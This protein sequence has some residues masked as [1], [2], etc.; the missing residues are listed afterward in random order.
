MSVS[1]RLCEETLP[2]PPF[3]IFY[4]VGS[5]PCQKSWTSLRSSD[6]SLA[7]AFYQLGDSPFVII[8]FPVILAVIY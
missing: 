4:T 8:M 2:H 1:I 3:Q 5:F 6:S 7:C